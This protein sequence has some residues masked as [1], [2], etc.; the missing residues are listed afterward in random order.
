M[1][2]L[3]TLKKDLIGTT[4]AKYTPGTEFIP[5]GYTARKVIAKELSDKDLIIEGSHLTDIRIFLRGH[6][7]CIQGISGP[8]FWTMYKEGKWAEV[9]TEPE[10]K[11]STQEELIAE[12]KERYPIG[13]YFKPVHV[14][15]PN[16]EHCKVVTEDF[17]ILGSNIYAV[18]PSGEFFERGTSD[19]LKYGNTQS[20]RLVKQGNRWAT[21]VHIFEKNDV[22]NIEEK[23]KAGDWCISPKLGNS[24]YFVGL[25]DS[26]FPIY[27]RIRNIL[28]IEPNFHKYEFDKAISAKGVDVTTNKRFSLNHS[29]S[30]FN[31]EMIK[32]NSKTVEQ[33]MIQPT[34][35]I[36]TSV[37][38]NC[39]FEDFPKMVRHVI[40]IRLYEY[41]KKVTYGI[42]NPPGKTMSTSLG[43]MFTWS[44]TVE[45]G[46]F[47]S[48]I[49]GKGTLK[50]FNQKYVTSEGVFIKPICPYTYEE[51]YAW[52][53]CKKQ[54]S[55]SS[56]LTPE[57]KLSDVIEVNTT[58]GVSLKNSRK[59]EVIINKTKKQIPKNKVS[60]NLTIKKTKTN[61][62]P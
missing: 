55:Y 52:A 62:K 41:E 8:S 6:D 38:H 11:L 35:S 59:L 13:T 5:V 42:P 2:A 31:K 51:L 14:I 24:S 45:G 56:F 34:Q 7:G 47:W 36:I 27:F 18:L 44:D 22:I 60:K 17:K 25:Q 19:T 9:M 46:L 4:I 15:T 43:T 33:L 50:T 58:S 40:L 23:F 37:K 21:A 16:T 49:Q 30:D 32:V 29:N 28:I 12:A 3:E 20:S 1:N 48:D 10:K 53:F 61:L 54:L 39:K 57:L 26:D